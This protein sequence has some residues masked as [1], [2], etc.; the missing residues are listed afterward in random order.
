MPTWPMGV[1]RR[2]QMLKYS[3]IYEGYRVQ[4][5]LWCTHSGG[6]GAWRCYSHVWTCTSVR[7]A[8]Y[9]GG[10]SWFPVCLCDLCQ[11]VLPM[12]SPD[13]L[14]RP[15]GRTQEVWKARDNFCESQ[16]PHID[17]LWRF[18]QEQRARRRQARPAA[19]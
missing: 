11:A 18:V 4:H 10:L 6:E 8:V 17:A 5:L 13:R 3:D 9:G 2:G 19:P 1:F 12:S 16:Q 15:H 14:G 7:L